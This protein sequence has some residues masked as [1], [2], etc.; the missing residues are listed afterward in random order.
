MASETRRLI[1][2]S[3]KAKE[4]EKSISIRTYKS[5]TW[6]FVD[7][8]YETIFLD[9]KTNKYNRLIIFNIARSPFNPVILDLLWLENCNL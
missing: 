5:H 9:V 1:Q 2:V 6:F 4:Q 7:V 3:R 8:I